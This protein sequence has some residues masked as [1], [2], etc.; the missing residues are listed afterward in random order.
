MCE[1]EALKE[2]SFENLDANVPGADGTLAIAKGAAMKFCEQWPVGLQGKGMIFT[3]NW[4]RG[5]THLAVAM[6]RFLIFERN[7]KRGAYLNERRLFQ[8]IRESYDD[9]ATAREAQILNPVVNDLEILAL[10]ELGTGNMSEWK[11][12]KLADILD[13][14]INKG[15]TTII[16]TNFSMKETGDNSLGER[17]G[18]LCYSRICM[19]CIHHAVTGDDFRQGDGRA[20]SEKLLY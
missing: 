7:V 14:R 19:M 2:L 4:G 3:G 12:D 18:R 11:R 1:V 5:K 15:L 13:T 16:T 10:D 20:T 9:E 8:T 17:I 6:L